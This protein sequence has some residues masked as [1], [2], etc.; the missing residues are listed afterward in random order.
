MFA[1]NVSAHDPFF[2]HCRDRERFV[3]HH[4]ERTHT[5]THT[6]H[7]TISKCSSVLLRSSMRCDAMRCICT[8]TCSAHTAPNDPSSSSTIGRRTRE[9]PF[10]I[11]VQG[12]A[13]SV[14][15]KSSRFSTKRISGTF[16][17]SVCV[18]V[19][20][21][22]GFVWDNRAASRREGCARVCLCVCFESAR[23]R[24]R[25]RRLSDLVLTV[26][27]VELWHTCFA[28]CELTC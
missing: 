10:R 24:H 22:S 15:E 16:F 27:T 6:K 9:T 14:S 25:R 8:L 21:F 3:E 20:V 2:G 18:C 11:R 13:A 7:N 17:S 26:R 4:T 19:C 23:R 5:C 28:T 1:C 12:Q